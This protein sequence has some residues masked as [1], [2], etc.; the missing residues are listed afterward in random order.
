MRDD[1]A[2]SITV[3]LRDLVE[4]DGG[5]VALRGFSETSISF[6][7][8]LDGAE[9]RECV[10][11]VDFLTRIMLDKGKKIVPTLQTI[12]IMDPRIENVD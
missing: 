7:L 2:N 11:P 4:I 3:A 9:C 6:E 8:I 10:M 12:Q 5:D 1:E